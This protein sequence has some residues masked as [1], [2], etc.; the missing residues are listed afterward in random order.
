MV[1]CVG[2]AEDLT[3]RWS[4]LRKA[5]AA[6]EPLC[7]YILTWLPHFHSERRAVPRP[8][9]SRAAV[10]GRSSAVAHLVLVRPTD[11]LADV[12]FPL[13]LLP[14]VAGVFA[15]G[16]AAAALLCEV[17]VFYAFQFRASSFWLV[18]F[19][20]IAANIVS[21]LIGFFALGFLPDPALGRR[22]IVYIAFFVAWALS[23]AIEYGLYF[24]VPRWR[25][26]SRLLPAV[27]LSNVASYLVLALALWREFA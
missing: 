27:A 5:R 17:L 18:L 22:W 10:A 6:G 4:E 3:R 14:Y 13:F 11:M 21:T 2:L 8:Q 7:V 16:F 9:R 23:V 1:L 20:V 24:A 25:R 12:V 19:A 26:F 15:P